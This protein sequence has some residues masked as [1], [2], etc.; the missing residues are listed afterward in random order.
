MQQIKEELYSQRELTLQIIELLTMKI[1]TS[2][3]NI[4]I[5]E[6]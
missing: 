3:N 5:K 6:F 4:F 2:N 1:F